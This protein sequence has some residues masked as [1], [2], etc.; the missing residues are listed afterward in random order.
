MEHIV[1]RCS[2]ARL[3]GIRYVAVE[4]EGELEQKNE[5]NLTGA[6]RLSLSP[7]LSFYQIISWYAYRESYNSVMLDAA[8]CLFT[9]LE[10]RYF[11][12]MR[13]YIYLYIYL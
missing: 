2:S 3:R 6:R 7:L 4:K 5:K 10:R 13:V 8:F 1:R 9:V 11:V 12:G